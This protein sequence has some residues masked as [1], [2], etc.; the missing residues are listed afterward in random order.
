MMSE[1]S[2][3]HAWPVTPAEPRG[4]GSESPWPL[5]S[6]LELGALP[7]AVPCA[8][9]HARLLLPEWGVGEL[10]DSVQI[11][12]TELVGNAVAASQSAEH[13]L[14]VKLWI[15]SDKSRVLV[16]VW[17]TIFQPPVRINADT[18][19]ESGRGLLLVEAI[20]EEWG[21]HPASGMEGKVV[22]ALVAE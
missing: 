14:P 19:A 16:A 2:Q 18:D 9:L 10:S 3:A 13:L 11:V 1:T 17:D 12:V 21:W 7:G 20:T 5:L 22:W 8:R 4:H 15:L 6:S